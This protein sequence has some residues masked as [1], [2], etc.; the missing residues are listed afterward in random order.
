LAI[1]RA[2]AALLVLGPLGAA[3]AEEPAPQARRVLLVGID[4]CRFDAVRA[5]ATPHL[6]RLVAAGAVHDRCQ[7]LGDRYREN[8]TISG[9][10]WSSILT[11]VWADKHGVLDN[12]FASPRYER[13]PHFFRRLKEAQPQA[14]TIS[15]ADWKPIA[16]QIVS[17]ADVSLAPGDGKDYVAAD[18]QT[19]A[20][21]ARLLAERD[22]LAMFVYFGQVDET[23]HQHGFHP[24][25]PEYR[26][27]IERV[28]GHLGEVLSAIAARP[29]P[30]A[31]EWLVLV[32]SDH[33]GKGTGHSAGH[34]EPEI[35]NSFLIVSGPSAAGQF[36]GPACL[37][38][39]VP[40]AL[41]FLRVEIHPAWELDGRPVGLRQR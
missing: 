26:Q 11:G 14:C 5:A 32:T 38:D 28:D 29:N 22:P 16:E 9:P 41:A 37:V 24:S 2:I 27:A 13:F 7:I 23:G 10:G 33:G 6:D 36:D 1:G 8:D 3:A 17:A 30:A 40:T 31:E 25:V 4:G 21:A 12:E 18:A 20:E 35:L 34:E 19:A 39:V 15:L